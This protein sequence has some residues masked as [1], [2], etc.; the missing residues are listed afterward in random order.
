MVHVK[1]CPIEREKKDI[2]YV[3]NIETLSIMEGIQ[4]DREA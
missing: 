3:N 1:V 2:R 4:D